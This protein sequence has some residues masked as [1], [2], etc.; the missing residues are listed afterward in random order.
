[1][2]PEVDKIYYKD[3]FQ[4]GMLLGIEYCNALMRETV[5]KNGK[6]L[7]PKEQDE[8]LS[9]LLGRFI[10]ENK[11]TFVDDLY[12]AGVATLHKNIDYDK[13]YAVECRMQN[14]K[15]LDGVEY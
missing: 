10:D 12:M 2:N 11:M 6:Y 9:H 5:D 14:E 13:L 8:V 3:A 15:E 7:D 4:Q 1:M